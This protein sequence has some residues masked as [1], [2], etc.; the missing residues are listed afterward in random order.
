MFRL[1]KKESKNDLKWIFGEMF[2]KEMR[3]L[4][5]RRWSMLIDDDSRSLLSDL[6]S[7][8]I[9]RSMKI[10]AIIGIIIYATAILCR[11]SAGHPNYNKVKL[12]QLFF[13][14]FFSFIRLWYKKNESID[15]PA[16]W[17]HVI[18]LAVKCIHG[19]WSR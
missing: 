11:I 14:P 8:R 1:N 18:T 15:T 19:F 4:N 17:I 6:I 9:Q 13:S 12:S 5:M 16:T 10:M 7:F 2:F 3:I